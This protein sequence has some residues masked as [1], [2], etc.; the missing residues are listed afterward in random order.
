M[1]DYTYYAFKCCS[2]NAIENAEKLG[3]TEDCYLDAKAI[4]DPRREDRTDYFY[5]IVDNNDGAV[6]NTRLFS[7]RGALIDLLNGV[8]RD[9]KMTVHIYE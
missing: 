1:E 5:A 4:T 3:F 7:N 9:V 2:K 8:S 6:L